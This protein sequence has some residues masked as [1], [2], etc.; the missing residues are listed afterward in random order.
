MPGKAASSWRRGMV[1]NG[2]IAK[3]HYKGTLDNG[4]VFDSTEGKEPLTFEVGTRQVVPGFE[5]AVREMQVGE[6]RT[7]RVGCREAFGEPQEEM[8]V[9][10]PKKGFPKNIDPQEGMVLQMQTQEGTLPAE[11]VDVSDDVVTLDANHPLVGEDLT[12]EV[13]LLEVA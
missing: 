1:R 6:T 11:I 10:I 7:V 4:S 2:Q 5:D 13:T 9:S 12:F 8:V 3:V